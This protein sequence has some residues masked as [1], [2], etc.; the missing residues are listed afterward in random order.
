MK[1]FWPL[2]VVLL[3]AGC[4]S[5]DSRRPADCATEDWFR[6]GLNHSDDVWALGG[7]QKRVDFFRK[8]CG[9]LFN[10]EAY[11]AGQVAAKRRES[12]GSYDP[13]PYGYGRT[14]GVYDP[15]YDRRDRGVRADLPDVPKDNPPPSDTPEPKTPPPAVK[16]DQ[17]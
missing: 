2:I 3:A 6:R 14:R 10:Q 7:E 15:R 8:A 13:Y 9:D 16:D 4:V 11:F 5:P 17:D 12:V 1:S